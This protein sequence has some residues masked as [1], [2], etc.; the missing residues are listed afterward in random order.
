MRC[1]T[2]IFILILTLS[3]LYSQDAVKSDVHLFQTFLR[4]ATITTNPYGDAGFQYGD[5]NYFN[6]W[7]LGIQGGYPVT[8]KVEVGA[9]LGFLDYS[10]DGGSS[11]SGLSDLFLS[12]RYL[13]TQ[14]KMNVTAGGFITLP[15]GGKDVGQNNFDFG[16]FGALRYPLTNGMVLTGIVGLDFL[17]IRNDRKTSLMIGGGTIYPVQ[18]NF[19][20]IG[21]LNIQTEIHYALLSGGVDYALAGGSR[22]RG[23]LGFGLDDGAPDFTLLGSFLFF[24]K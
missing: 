5:Y 12:G 7:F 14:E 21:E 3:S 4:D 20:I 17:E 22:I 6:T 9:R 11:E 16:G 2:V 15:I 8:P 13:I 18:E 10:F 24:L 1:L 19:S 23:A